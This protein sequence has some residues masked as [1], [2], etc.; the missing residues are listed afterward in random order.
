M[1][2]SKLESIEVDRLRVGMYVVLDAAGP[3]LGFDPNGAILRSESDVAR[4][5]AAGLGRVRYAPGLSEVLPLPAAESGWDSLGVPVLHVRSSAPPVAIPTPPAGGEPTGADGCARD[6]EPSPMPPA[7]VDEVRT[8]GA[9]AEVFEGESSRAAEV[10]RRRAVLADQQASLDRCEMQFSEVSRQLRGVLQNARANPAQ[11]REVAVAQVRAMV[12]Q[13]DG[14]EDVAIR[15]LS[16]KAGQETT[17]HA[18]NVSVLAILL[19]R[20]LKFDAVQI[21]H[22]GLGAL[23]HDIGKLELPDRL[24][25]RDDH[26]SG[27]ER[28]LFQEHAGHGVALAK[29]M[30]LPADAIDVIAQH[31]EQAD[32]GGY[33]AG[34][35]GPQIKPL[36]RVVAL[37][38][39]YD[40]FCNP[41]NPAHA[42][43][44]HDALALLFA[45]HRD[46]FDS[47]V[48][49]AFIRM[50]GVYPPGS[51]LQLHDDRYAIV[52]SVNPDRPL[53]PRVLIHDPEVPADEALVVD[54]EQRTDIGIQRAVKPFQLPRA[55]FD[56]LSPR[57]RMCYFFERSAPA[58]REAPG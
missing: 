40:N 14:V 5:R 51:V 11:A 46:A 43:T 55:V 18:M 57:K 12:G 41:G 58:S 4:L 33:P 44:P 56:Y 6:A 25:W 38:N 20:A 24:R 42:L 54:L 45:R 34:L 28:R 50:M 3:P 30:G 35:K 31:H 39:Q 26:A 9:R 37:V 48:L 15:L 13:V 49:A 8:D 22:L 23:L 2:E 32:G 53:K 16:E 29:K 47:A 52:A 7:P 17:L 10:A 19:G 36:A 27:V 1:A 21:G